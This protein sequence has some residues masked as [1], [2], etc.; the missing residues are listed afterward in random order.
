[1]LLNQICVILFAVAA[2]DGD[3][4]DDDD[5]KEVNAN[6]GYDFHINL[7]NSV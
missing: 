4:D 6:N 1:M 7:T 3:D 5:K 2:A